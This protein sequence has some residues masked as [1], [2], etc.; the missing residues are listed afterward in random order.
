MKRLALGGLEVFLAIARHGS[1]SAAAQALGIGSPA[2]SHQLK[3]FEQ[4]LGVDLFSRTTRSV[5][6]TAAGHA[7]MARAEPAFAELGE[8]IED[9]RGIGRSKTGTLRLTLPWS[10]YKIAIAPVLGA[11]QSA[12]PDVELEMSFSEALVDVVREGFHAGIRLGDRLTEGMIAVRLTPPLPAAYSAA[13]SYLDRYGRPKH[14]RDL[15]SHK[16]IRY[17]FISASRLA[18]WQFQEDGRVFTVDP[19][20]DLTFDGFQAV[21]QAARA[22]HGIGWSLRG[23]IEDEVASAELETVLDDYTIEHPPFY[24]YYPDQ[25][26]RL[27]LLRLLIEFL[28]SE[29]P[30]GPA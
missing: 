11:F 10:A 24:L 20:A 18:D 13:P 28:K 17:R 2:V 16:C 3:S 9:A 26:G 5:E 22:G 21:T 25:N 6:L 8:A 1:F 7:L 15:L 12:Y 19:G 30:R 4:R 23:V 29:R 27:E 14:P